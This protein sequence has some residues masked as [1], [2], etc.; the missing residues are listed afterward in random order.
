[1]RKIQ[2][3]AWDKVSKE[4]CYDPAGYSG[5]YAAC[6]SDILADNPN[7]MQFTGL[8]DKAGVDIYEGDILD[9][10]PGKANH[11]S[12]ILEVRWHGAGFGIFKDNNYQGWLGKDVA[13]NSQ[14]IGNVHEGYQKT[15]SAG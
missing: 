11:A 12:G 8:Q 15:V 10:Q 14:V 2:F 13:E 9:K 6:F 7:L 5:D 4:M 3:R 1:M